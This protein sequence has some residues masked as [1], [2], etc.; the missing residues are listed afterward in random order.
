MP[1]TRGASDADVADE[2]IRQLASL[3]AASQHCVFVTGAGASTNAGLRDYRGPNGIWTEAQAAGI[4]Q[5]DPGEK[6]NRNFD[7]PWDDDMYRLHALATPTLT[8]RAITQLVVMGRV[9]HVISQ[10]EDGLHRRAGLPAEHLSEVHGNAFVELCS[11]AAKGAES[12]SDSSDSDS[13]DAAEEA[14]KEEA[15]VLRPA[16]CGAAIVRDFVTYHGDTY[17]RANAAG[18]H[19]TRRACPRCHPDGPPSTSALPRVGRGWLL[20]STVDFGESPDGLPWGANPVHNMVAARVHMQHADLVVVWGSS[21]S[22]LANY[23]DPW[24]P[25]SKWAKPPPKGVRLAPAVA[26]GAEAGA[27]AAAAAQGKRPKRAAKPGACKLAIV[28]RGDA[29][30]EEFAVLK[31]EDDVDAVMQRLLAALALP[32]PPPYEPQ[33]DPLLMAAEPLREGEPA[34]APW[35]LGGS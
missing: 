4:V 22:I 2:H 12:S 33:R 21:L 20:D 14:A 28:T 24:C 18:R 32:E 8:H 17:K 11:A 29:T 35:K 3:I 10:N 7:C 27:A 31:I 6:I 30:D 25:S 13:E 26:S 9:K 23:F 16:G 15:R 5:G 34:G 19:V 1:L